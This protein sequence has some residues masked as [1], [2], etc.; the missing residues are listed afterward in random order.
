MAAYLTRALRKNTD[1]KFERYSGGWR[2]RL[3]D[4]DSTAYLPFSNVV[5]ALEVE[6]FS[7]PQLDPIDAD[8]VIDMLNSGKPLQNSNGAAISHFNGRIHWLSDKGDNP[9][10]REVTAQELISQAWYSVS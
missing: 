7:Y 2:L 1:V 4:A 10:D 5:G 8:A 9:Y 3:E 6:P